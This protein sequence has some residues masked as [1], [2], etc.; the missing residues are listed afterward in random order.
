[1]HTPQAISSNLSKIRKTKDSA[2]T[3]PYRIIRS[4]KRKTVGLQVKKGKVVVRAPHFVKESRI[5]NL[6]KE[7]DE[8]LR[9]HLEHQKCFT[10]QHQTKF[11]DQA[12]LLIRGK[13]KKLFVTYTDMNIKKAFSSSSGVV[14]EE[15]RLRLYLAKKY[16]KSSCEYISSRIKLRLEQWLKQ[17]AHLMIEAKLEEYASTMQLSYKSLKIRQ[18][19]NRWGS[20]SNKGQLS[21]NYLLSMTP[22][23]V[24]D[25]VIVHEL[26]HLVHLNHSKNFW[27]LVAI[28]YPD[29]QLAKRWL[30]ENQSDL[31][32]S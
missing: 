9:A 13:R 4:D 6:V 2:V 16:Q 20:C 22:Q 28:Y 18:Y 3:I 30:K 10:E 21:F 8:W 11:V 12:T 1:M 29:Y 32:W 24:V 7:K 27:H 26:C 14:E 17:E 5:A 23:W 19:K 25:Y 15:D 31:S